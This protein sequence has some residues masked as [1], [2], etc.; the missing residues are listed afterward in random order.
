[1]T[2]LDYNRLMDFYR[3]TSLATTTTSEAYVETTD[4]TVTFSAPLHEYV[5]DN[6]V[7]RSDVV[8]DANILFRID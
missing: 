2:R 8:K 7:F 4:S 5:Y 6:L 1:M 3:R